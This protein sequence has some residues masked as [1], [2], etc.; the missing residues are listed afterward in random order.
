[1]TRDERIAKLVHAIIDYRGK[2]DEHSGK[3][4]KPPQP[5]RIE[6]IVRWCNRLKLNFTETMEKVNGF[7]HYDEFMKWVKTL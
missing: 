5:A 1:M 4:F 7:Q 3:W 2:Y 6:G